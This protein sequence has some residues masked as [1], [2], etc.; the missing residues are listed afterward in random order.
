MELEAI[1]RK[2]LM[3]KE[4]RETTERT[5]DNNEQTEHVENHEEENIDAEEGETL[6]HENNDLNKE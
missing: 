4:G 1:K 2:V 3:E 6:L 5:A